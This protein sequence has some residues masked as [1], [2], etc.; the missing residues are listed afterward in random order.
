MKQ[1]IYKSI[2]A[3]MV[4]S[5]ISGMLLL[6]IPNSVITIVGFQPTEE[7]WISAIGLLALSL[8]FYYFQ[9]ARSGS[10]KAVMGTV[11]GRW[12]FTSVATVAALFGLVPLLII[13]MM[14]FE[15]SLAVWALREANVKLPELVN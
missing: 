8:C 15:A 11:Y 6:T 10:V 14:I 1:K 7:R 12:F 13:P 2:Y 9:I 3:Q 5:F 4:Y